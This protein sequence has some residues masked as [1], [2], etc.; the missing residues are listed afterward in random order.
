MTR[1]WECGF[2]LEG[3][4]VGCNRARLGVLSVGGGSECGARG[5]AGRSEFEQKEDV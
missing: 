5:S 4:Q 1:G 2:N 3:L